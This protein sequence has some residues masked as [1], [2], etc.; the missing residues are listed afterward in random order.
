MTARSES[1]VKR[2]SLDTPITAL[3]TLNWELVLYTIFFALAIF[4]R[5]YEL[6]D[7]V[8]S[9]DESL[10]TLYSWN[11]YAG[12]GYQHDPLMHGPTLFHFTAL[13][14]FLFGDND[15]TARLSAAI[16]GVILVILPY[17]FRP[18]LGRL[19][20]LSASF[21]LLISPGIL[22]YTRYIRHF[23][24]KLPVWSRT[25]IRWLPESAT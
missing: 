24:R 4:T 18:W 6:G 23:S 25:W 17:W 1:V 12:K 7:R 3:F 8:M 21:M 9:H 13:M 19:G 2:F 14:Y 15:F 16:F 5:L 20:A 10:H 11:L 22:Y